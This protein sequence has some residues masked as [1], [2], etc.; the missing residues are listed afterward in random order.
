VK[1]LRGGADVPPQS[2]GRELDA[3]PTCLLWDR[4]S[5]LGMVRL[6]V[7]PDDSYDW[8]EER[9]RERERF[10]EDGAW[11]VVGEY[12]VPARMGDRDDLTTAYGDD[13]AV[14]RGTGG[15]RGGASEGAWGM[16]T[17][18]VPTRTRTSSTSW[19]RRL[20]G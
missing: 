18:A 9:E 3:A 20:G 5:D 17:W 4:L 11:G 14:V 13:S 10:G 2:R 16:R 8:S 1:I 7:K 6:E 19:G 12:R 15:G